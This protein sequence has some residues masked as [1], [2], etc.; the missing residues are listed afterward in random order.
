M[1]WRRVVL[2]AT[3]VVAHV[4]AVLFFPAGSVPHDTPEQDLSFTTVLVPEPMEQQTSRPEQ[5]RQAAAA[6]SRRPGE[7]L[8]ATRSAETINANQNA[9]ASN[10]LQPD[11]APNPAP[12]IDWAIEAQIVA[13][14]RVRQDIE[15]S[16]QGV[17][18]SQRRSHVMPSPGVPGAN[19]FRW[20]YAV[21]HRLESSALGLTVNL[22]DRCSLLVSIYMMAIMGGCKIGEI[23]VHGD[24]FVHMN[25]DPESSA[26]ARH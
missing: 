21:T 24:L 19:T 26:Q 1:R 11:A 20:D 8:R 10:E 22:S 17:A 3:V 18:L 9:A 25:D 23:P 13:D 12:Q 16:R 4:L 2:F 6:A 5:Q 14:D 7:T 15:S